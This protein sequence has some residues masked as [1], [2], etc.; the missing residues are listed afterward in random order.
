MPS[1]CRYATRRAANDSP[2]HQEPIEYVVE[3][4]NPIE[5]LRGTD[6]RLKPA[7]KQPREA[8]A[9]LPT[10][11]PPPAAVAAGTAAV[12]PA[13]LTSAG[14]GGRA[15]GGGGSGRG[16]R[17]SPERAG[18]SNH[19]SRD[20]SPSAAAAAAGTG[21]DALV[22][23]PHTRPTAPPTAP[24][25][26]SCEMLVVDDSRRNRRVL[27]RT[28]QVL[29]TLIA[30]AELWLILTLINYP[31]FCHVQ[32][33]GYACDEADDG[34]TAV[35]KVCLHCMPGALSRSRGSNVMFVCVCMCGGAG[36]AASGRGFGGR[37]GLVRRGADGHHHA[38]QGRRRSRPRDT[39]HG[40]RT[41]NARTHPCHLVHLC[42]ARFVN[43]RMIA[44]TLLCRSGTPTN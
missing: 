18:S 22:V 4:R 29:V 31:L 13:P 15:G 28:L 40:V 25:R 36:A 5:L 32:L 43:R 9:P 35:D 34:Q 38:H 17:R 23:A 14:G 10:S 37:G 33:A 8:V 24:G 16:S 42:R 12:A 39:R 3:H 11:E 2:S 6:L 26:R 30:H 1:S 41:P 20:D 19:S 7:L 21:A 44:A 27:M